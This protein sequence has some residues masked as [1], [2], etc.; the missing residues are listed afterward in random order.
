MTRCSAFTATVF[1]ALVIF[2]APARAAHIAI[3]DSHPDFITFA[4]ADF[5][6]GISVNGVPYAGGFLVLPDGEYTIEGTWLDNGANA[7]GATVQ[8]LYA[9]TSQPDAVTSGILFDVASDGLLAT[10][11]G[12]FGGFVGAPYFPTGDPTIDQASGLIGNG[13]AAFLTV[14]FIPETVPEPSTLGLVALGALA[15]RRACTGQVRR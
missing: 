7:G 13:A 15:W 9:F 1:A 6:V 4:A 2:G 3:D 5:E 12:G 8:I 11:N 14:E 10:L